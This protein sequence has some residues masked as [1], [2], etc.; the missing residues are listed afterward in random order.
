MTW[1]VLDVLAWSRL[2]LRCEWQEVV[3]LA[4]EDLL[5]HCQG[6]G[7]W[8]QEGR[9]KVPSLLHKGDRLEHFIVTA[10]AH[11][12]YLLNW[13]V[14]RLLFTR[15]TRCCF[16]RIKF[17]DQDGSLKLGVVEAELLSYQTSILVVGRES[18]LCVFS[19]RSLVVHRLN[20]TKDDY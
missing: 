6:H 19:E 5:T 8:H 9:R 7:E 2:R 11:N 14:C 12:T 1:A 16:Y 17:A 3:S 13:R 10:D 15:D 18:T 20:C 4:T